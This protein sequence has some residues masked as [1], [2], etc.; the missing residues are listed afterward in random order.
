MTTKI[1]E[2]EGRLAAILSGELDTAAAVQLETD[3]APLFQAEDMDVVID[4]EDVQ[5]ISSG[6]L[7]LFFSLLK[8]QKE[9]GHKVVIA[10]LSDDLMMVF[11]MAGFDRFYEFE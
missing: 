1:L 11:K 6:G 8:S 2:K 9:K 10:H 3:F 5:Y 4:C 7:R